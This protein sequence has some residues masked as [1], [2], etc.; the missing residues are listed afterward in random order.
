MARSSY[1]KK[2]T[3]ISIIAS[4]IIEVFIV[5]AL[6]HGL[7]AI[8][9]LTGISGGILLLVLAFIA[10]YYYINGVEHSRRAMTYIAP[11]G[12]A[13]GVSALLLIIGSSNPIAYVFKLLFTAYLFELFVGWFLRIDY[14]YYSK[15]ASWI[16][17]SGILIFTISLALLNYTTTA[18]YLSLAGNTIKIISLTELLKRIS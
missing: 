1:F 7:N 12:I 4:L 13:I 16:F 3:I 15:Q 8:F 9:T 11:L 2:A 6:L 17:F 10:Y 5:L 18:L 14:G